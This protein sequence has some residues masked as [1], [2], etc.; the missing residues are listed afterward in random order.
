MRKYAI[1]GLAIIISGIVILMLSFVLNSAN[2]GVMSPL[3]LIGGVIVL[4]N[5]RKVKSSLFVCGECDLTFLEESD[6]Y[7]HYAIEHTKK[8]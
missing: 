1:T 7:Q 6:L 4:V 2:V 5:S 8:D 3:L